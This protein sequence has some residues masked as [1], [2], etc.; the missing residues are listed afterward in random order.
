MHPVLTTVGSLPPPESEAVD[1]LGDAVRFQRA[2]GMALLTDGEPRGDMLSLYT[3]LQGIREGHG[4]PRVVDRV[5]P[6]EDPSEF[7]KVRD[8]DT[9]RARFPEERFKVCLTGPATFLISCASGGA[10]PAYRG[11]MDPHLHDDLT[12]AL[13]PI[14]HEIAQRGAH[15]QIDEPILS[16]GMRD[17]S[18]ALRRL[19]SLA[20]EASRDRASVHVCG[21]LAR[22]KTLAALLRLEHISVLSLAFAGKLE[23]ENRDLLEPGPWDDR[24]MS[25]G[26][27]AIDVQVS[28][29]AEVMTADAVEK[30]LGEIAGRIGAERIAFVHPDCGLRATPP[31]LAPS[32][33]DNLARGYRRAFPG[34]G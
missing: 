14:A 23:V 32:L 30:L 18:P 1:P 33:L 2:R 4:V 15:L 29:P 3:Q 13:R 8:L 17:F 19:D 7:S 6:M 26:A 24:A 12:E 27:G 25:L 34:E 9:L 5:R 11:P 20:S 16:Q 28:S 21:G 31:A 22:S 10:G